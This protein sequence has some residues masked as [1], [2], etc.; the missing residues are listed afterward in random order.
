MAPTQLDRRV[1]ARVELNAFS[2]RRSPLLAKSAGL[3][4]SLNNDGWKAKYFQR[5][6]ERAVWV[7]VRPNET[8]ASLRQLVKVVFTLFFAG[9]ED[10]R[11]TGRVAY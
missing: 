4:V 1:H 7:W 11:D 9:N 2:G 3:S 6:L 8:N 10:G 5:G